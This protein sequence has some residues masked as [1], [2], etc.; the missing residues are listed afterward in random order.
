MKKL[1]IFCTSVAFCSQIYA[2]DNNTYIKAMG[3]GSISNQLFS[4]S[5]IDK[6]KGNDNKVSVKNPMSNIGFGASLGIGYH[7]N[8]KFRIETNITYF[9]N[10]TWN[11]L[12]SKTETKT[13]I[14]SVPSVIQ[15]SRGVTINGVNMGN[16]LTSPQAQ[17][18]SNQSV[19]EKN[20]NT[21]IS[22]PVGFINLYA[23]IIN[24]KQ[25]KIYVGGGLGVSHIEIK[26]CNESESLEKELKFAWNIA[27]GLGLEVSPSL[28]VDAGYSFNHL[29]IPGKK[30]NSEDLQSIK[31][32][33]INIG[34][35]F[36]L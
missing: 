6:I 35:R 8:E 23:D 22:G 9:F 26:N 28:I 11:V 25:A 34:V 19:E 13:T 4:D 3:F 5:S 36:L 31:S 30:E 7:L 24:I 27:A 18:I 16:T 33:N 10:Q 21:S 1:I 32:H 14:Q 29:G 15:A 20:I 17:T 2:S 12:S